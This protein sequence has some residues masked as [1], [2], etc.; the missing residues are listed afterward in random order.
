MID[1]H[2]I[3]TVATSYNDVKAGDILAIIGSSGFL[4]ISVNQGN[5]AEL[6]KDREVRVIK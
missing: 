1:G 5:A 4:E 6:I 2:I 3:D